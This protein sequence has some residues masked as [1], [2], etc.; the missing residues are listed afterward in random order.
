ARGHRYPACPIPAVNAA[1]H[2]GNTT[3]ASNRDAQYII[4]SPRGT[5]PD[6]YNT[7]SGQFCAW[8]DW[9]GDTTLSGGAV[10]SPYGDIAFTNSPTSPTWAPPAG[11]TSSTAPAPWIGCRS[12]TGTSTPRPSPTTTRP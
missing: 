11:R 10:T 12:S 6:G 7:P 4:V 2:F 1:A 5:H 9:N 8:H 3:A